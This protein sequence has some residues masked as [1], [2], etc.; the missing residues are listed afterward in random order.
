[1]NND[2]SL[3]VETRLKVLKALS[4]RLGDR[5][6]W[7]QHEWARDSAGEPCEVGDPDARQWCLGGAVQR[8]IEDLFS[9]VGDGKFQS[10]RPGLPVVEPGGLD[11]DLFLGG[12]YWDVASH[13]QKAV[14]RFLVRRHGLDEEWKG[15]LENFNDCHDWL[16]VRE[17]VDEAKAELAASLLQRRKT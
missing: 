12:W 6:R 16:E 9:Q 4:E 10:E 17:I 15:T 5:K 11:E 13:L 7:I 2:A 14:G 3:N 1:M 8:E